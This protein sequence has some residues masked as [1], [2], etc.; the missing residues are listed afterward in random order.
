MEK[1]ALVSIFLIRSLLVVRNASFV[2][3]PPLFPANEHAV[4]SLLFIMFE[5]LKGL[6]KWD[7]SRMRGAH[8]ET[9]VVSASEFRQI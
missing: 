9:L 7:L 5:L 1:G 3:V 6:T 4:P 8:L 2:R